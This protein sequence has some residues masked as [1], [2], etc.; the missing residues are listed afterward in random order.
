M[1]EPI[2]I[3]IFKDS[4]LSSTVISPNGEFAYPVAMM[5]NKGTPLNNTIAAWAGSLCGVT[6]FFLVFFI[7]ASIFKKFL[8]TNATY[9]AAKYYINKT[10]PLFGILIALPKLFIIPVF[11]FGITRMNFTKFLIIAAVYRAAFY[12]Y[13]LYNIHPLSI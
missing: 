4:F 7:L 6:V 2:Y 12:V 8:E 9:P 13:S 3:S 11:F 5:L 10:S 1:I